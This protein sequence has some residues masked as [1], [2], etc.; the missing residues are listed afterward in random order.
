M[1]LVRRRRAG[2]ALLYVCGWA[3]GMDRLRVSGQFTRRLRNLDL[4]TLMAGLAVSSDTTTRLMACF[5]CQKRLT[6]GNFQYVY[7]IYMR[8]RN[9]T[10]TDESDGE[11][12]I[13]GDAPTVLHS[14]WLIASQGGDEG[15]SGH[16]VR[17]DTN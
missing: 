11:T 2:L 5:A 16:L 1:W 3:A 9:T 10:S 8:R 7:L 15:G 17:E 6:P 4:C 13:L 14:S 12:L